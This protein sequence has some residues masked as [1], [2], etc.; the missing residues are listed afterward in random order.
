MSRMKDWL[1]DMEEA[2][3]EALQTK[4]KSLGEV[5]NYVY[6]KMQVVDDDFIRQLWEQHREGDMSRPQ[7]T[8]WN[9]K[10]EEDDDGY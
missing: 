10:A 7:D 6:D 9:G 1:M 2:F 5:L 3:G 8:Q 4:P